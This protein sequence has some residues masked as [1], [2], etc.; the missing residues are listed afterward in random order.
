MSVSQMFLRCAKQRA[1]FP[2]YSGVNHI[3]CVSDCQSDN[4]NIRPIN[5]FVNRNPRNL[6]RLRLKPTDHG[7]GMEWEGY[8]KSRSSNLPRRNY[9]Y[10]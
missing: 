4:A 2:V 9:Y 7:W 5:N 6:E 3:R 8:A 1:T 10:R